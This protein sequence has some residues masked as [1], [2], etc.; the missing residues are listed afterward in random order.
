MGK[1]LI[2]KNI[3]KGFTQRKDGLYQT[4]YYDES[5]KKC[6]LYDTNLRK[7]QQEKKTKEEEICKIK[8][9]LIKSSYRKM[10]TFEEVYNDFYENKIPILRL[11]PRTINVYIQMYEQFIKG[12]SEI[13]LIKID[14]FTTAYC[15]KILYKI[16][17]EHGTIQ[18]KVQVLMNRVF[19]YA[20]S[21]EL[22]FKNPCSKIKIIKTKKKKVKPLPIKDQI[23]IIE[24]DKNFFYRNF[25]ILALHTGLRVSEIAGLKESDIDISNK[26]LYVRRQLQYYKNCA[27]NEKKYDYHYD[28]TKTESGI[29]AV[30]LDD[31]AIKAIKNQLSMF[32]RRACEKRFKG[33]LF[34]NTKGKPITVNMVN[35][36]LK[37][38][39]KNKGTELSV[40][41]LSSHMF[42]HSFATNCV[43]SDVEYRIISKLL[44]HSTCY[45]TDTYAHITESKLQESIK[46]VETAYQNVI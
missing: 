1:S 7:L 18:D 17:K 25:C 39:F 8:N 11:K 34:L 9:I 42:R 36:H 46:K 21:C 10:P 13:G 2:G 23:N 28:E 3:G 40:D 38:L 12:T 41:R 6:Y 5:H 19:E 35:S 26:M 32:N 16:Y 37:T 33:L 45:S 22:I 30:P 20:I 4:Y 24:N 29:R 14:Q 44:G 15:E 27:L 43:N 31:Q